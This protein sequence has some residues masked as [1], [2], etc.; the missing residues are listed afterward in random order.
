MAAHF[1]SSS[2]LPSK[3]GCTLF[4]GGYITL[5]IVVFKLVLAVAFGAVVLWAL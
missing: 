2:S 5:V 3:E 4:C 1:D